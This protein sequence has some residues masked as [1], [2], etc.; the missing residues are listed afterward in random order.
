VSAEARPVQRE[1]PRPIG[2]IRL[3]WLNTIAG[4]S[5]FSIR[6][7]KWLLR[8]G[9]VD[10]RGAG[11]WP[12][13]KFISG[14]NVTI[15]DRSFVNEG[16]L[17][18]AREHIEIGDGVAVGPR[19]MFLTSS[20]RMGPAGYRAGDAEFA[21]I[22]VEGGSWI[23]AGSIVLGGV[24]IGRGCVIGAGAVVTTNCE[25]NGLYVGT[26]AR[27]QADLPQEPMD[28]GQSDAAT[29]KAQGAL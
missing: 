8:L 27:R 26:P 14:R 1:L 12:S 15:G 19:V 28:R 24:T 5:I 29:T 3:F 7:R 25:P 22:V 23:G 13:V 21:P 10:V 4:S 9:G 18:D 17:F 2:T 16:V 20:H 6:P 11:V